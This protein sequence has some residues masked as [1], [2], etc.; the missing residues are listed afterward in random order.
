MKKVWPFS[1]YFLY[2]AAIAAYAPYMVLYF[3]SAN[4]SGAQIGLLTGI[5]PLITLVS[6]PFWTGLADKTDKHQLIMSMAMVV[7]IT[8][9]IIFPFLDT[10]ILIFGMGIVFQAF[11]SSVIP[12]SDSA[13]MFMLGK[14]KDIYGRVRLG[15]TIG[16]GLTATIAGVLVENNGIKVAFWSAAVLFFIGF[17]VSQ[18][19]QHGKAAKD[20][21]ASR[22]R[23][24]QLLKN[25]Q[26]IIFLILAFTGGH[27]LCS[28]DY[29]FFP[30]YEGIGCH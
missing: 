7:G 9:L 16:F 19:L 11:F 20:R 6:V 21:S 13:T 22:Q 3:Q 26:W 29:L 8:V 10:F 4:L 2:Y 28:F 18:K 30:V 23:M 5:T 17:L 15:G 27:D 1:F 12:I 25:P 24:G 14:Q